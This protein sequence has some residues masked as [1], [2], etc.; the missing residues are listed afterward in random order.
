MSACGNRTTDL[1]DNTAAGGERVR[2]PSFSPRTSASWDPRCVQ[3]APRRNVNGSILWLKLLS[4]TIPTMT[5]DP[6]QNKQSA[7]NKKQQLNKADKHQRLITWNK[8]FIKER[9]RVIK[10]VIKTT[11]HSVGDPQQVGHV[12][13]VSSHQPVLPKQQQ[14]TNKQQ[15]NRMTVILPTSKQ[16]WGTSCD[17]R[18]LWWPVNR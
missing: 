9:R 14:Q 1:H 15:P 3:G 8:T 5:F 16:L 4:A 10:K 2:L 11:S 6:Q 13:Q 18:R 7:F 12:T 17:W